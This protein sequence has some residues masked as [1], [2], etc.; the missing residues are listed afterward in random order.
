MRE[1]ASELDSFVVVTEDGGRFSS[2]FHEA[3]GMRRTYCLHGAKGRKAFVEKNISRLACLRL[4]SCLMS[5]SEKSG[6]DFETN[7][8]LRFSSCESAQHRNATGTTT[9][10]KRRRHRRLWRLT[11]IVILWLTSIFVRD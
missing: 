2:F 4:R 11:S 5:N 9:T 10:S 8:L 6:K 1:K 3:K 7:K